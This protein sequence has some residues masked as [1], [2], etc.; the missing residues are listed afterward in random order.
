[1]IAGAEE[2]GY[3]AMT[4]FSDVADT[5]GDALND[6]LLRRPYATLAGA[7]GIGGVS[8]PKP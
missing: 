6:S 8:S 5:F 3:D 1:M 4:A 2:K 7:A